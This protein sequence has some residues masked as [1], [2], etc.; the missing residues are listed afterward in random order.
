MEHFVHC[1]AQSDGMNLAAG[2]K[3]PAKL[4]YNAL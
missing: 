3:E 1:T 4:K 2:G